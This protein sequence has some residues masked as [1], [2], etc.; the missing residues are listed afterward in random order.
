MSIVSGFRILSLS[1]FFESQKGSLALNGICC[2]PTQ[3]FQDKEILDWRIVRN[4]VSD[5][6]FAGF[7]SDIPIQDGSVN[8]S[9]RS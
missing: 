2:D 9:Q 3:L 5:G 6:F 7:G 1:R 4:L 8:T